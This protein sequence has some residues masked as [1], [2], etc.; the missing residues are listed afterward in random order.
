M[1]KVEVFLQVFGI[2]FTITGIIIHLII[3]KIKE[4]NEE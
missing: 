1:F 2:T 4:G 3:T